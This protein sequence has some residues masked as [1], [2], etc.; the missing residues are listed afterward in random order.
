MA[1]IPYADSHRF[2]AVLTPSALADDSVPSTFV[3]PDSAVAFSIS[4]PDDTT[5]DIFFSIRAQT[6][7]AWAAIGLGS[8][9]MAGALILMIYPTENGQN[10]TFSPRLVY[11]NYEP[12]YWSTLEHEVISTHV[13]EDYMTFTARCIGHCQSWPARNTNRGFL[14]IS[15]SRE[16]AIY[17]VGPVDWNFGSD[18]P[19]V[20]VAFH[21]MHGT[22]NIDIGRTRGA[23]DAP[24]MNDTSP[25]TGA[26]LVSSQTDKPDWRPIIHGTFMMLAFLLVLPLGVWARRLA[27]FN[28]FHPVIQVFGYGLAMIG[29]ALGV[30]ASK[31]YQRSLHFNSYHQIIGFLIIFFLQV[32]LFLGI[33][34]RREFNRTKVQ[35]KGHM[36]HTWLGRILIFFGAVNALL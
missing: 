24:V 6:K 4:V 34:N 16:E 3:S 26:T 5:T 36:P 22:F 15:S 29:L 17:A 27:R 31:L 30:Y 25:N 1:C 19:S 21:E 11:G 10:V 23:K 12:R 28:R 14:D 7:R 8:T 18:D 9:E 13:D 20:G 32:Q 35:P 2:R 33:Y